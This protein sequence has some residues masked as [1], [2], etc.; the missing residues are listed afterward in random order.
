MKL[1]SVVISVYNEEAVL[2]K[3][4]DEFLKVSH[5][6]EWDWELL[7]VND[8]SH[9]K[10]YSIL[11]EIATEDK[12]VKIINFSRNFGHEAA[13]IAGIDFAE[14]SAIICMDADL[15]HPLESIP[16]IINKFEVGY[17]IVNMVRL[18]NKSAGFIKEITSNGFYKVINFLADNT[19]FEKN[20]SDFFGIS[21]NVAN[22]LKNN[23]REKNRFLR[24]YVQNMGF[25]KTSLEYTAAQR[26]A[27][28]SHYSMRKLFSF[29]IGAIVGF[30]NMPLKLGIWAGIVSGLIGVLVLLY[31]LFTYRSAPS[32]YATIVVMMCFLFAMMFVI[33]GIIGQYIAIL[34]SEIK[35]RPIYIVKDCCNFSD[36][37]G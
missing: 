31:T 29:S 9:D 23:Y 15:Q 17:D 6:I 1:L 16:Q 26:A 12:R 20:A 25:R 24:G 5:F 19:R 4:Y 30:S 7:F 22:V 21:R 8:G 37:K 27:G 35:D 36:L 11:K 33:I 2:E 32:G 13:M 28:A 18:S 14:G 34:F 3:F 10:S